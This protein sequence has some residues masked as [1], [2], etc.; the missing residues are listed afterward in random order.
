MNQEKFKRRDFIGL[1]S[2]TSI[3]GL[4][5]SPLATLAD[6][7][8]PES[9][10]SL[11]AEGHT[12]LTQPYL[13]HPGTDGMTIMWITA[14]DAYS[15]VEYQEKGGTTK[16]AHA[17]TDGMV[18][19]ND[20]LHKVSLQELKPG[21]I[22]TYKVYAKEILSYEPYK[23]TYGE[24]IESSTYEFT[25]LALNPA[26][27]SLL[28]MNDIHDRP[29][30]IPQLMALNGNDPYDFVFFNGDIFDY[31]TDENQIIKNMINPCTTAFASTK[32][33]M[34]VR[35]NHETRG[36]FARQLPAYFHNLDG[37]QYFS[38]T[39][40]PVHFIA[41][42]TGED[43]E[44]NHPVYAGLID[45]DTYRKKQAI[46]LETQLKSKAYKK[47]KFKVVIMHIPHYH[48]GDGHGTL[49]CREVFGPLFNKYKIDL[50]ICG[51]THTYKVHPPEEGHQFPIIIGG[52][53]KDG[54]RTLIK[55]K[56]N[57]RKLHL[58]ML[59]DNGQEVGNYELSR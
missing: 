14:R 21:T 20:R 43:K 38:F 15:W 34:Y 8:V 36:K 56:A 2:K 52:G 1:V 4:A 58:S 50:M 29:Q 28:I 5:I 31:Q 11:P 35:G 37:G 59:A 3:L 49:H 24:T 9:K 30:S 25:T 6:S 45:F 12:F 44:D 10:D 7:T 13:Q 33:F 22:Y 57:E 32:P 27:V 23:I 54:K 41:L 51:H 17:V 46:W 55:L 47:A 40:G 18:D 39:R 19:A 48:S 26:E 42:D 16:K 53:P